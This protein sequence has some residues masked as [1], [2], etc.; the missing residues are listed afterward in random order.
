MTHQLNYRRP[1]KQPDEGF[2]WRDTMPS[3]WQQTIGLV[4]CALTGVLLPIWFLAVFGYWIGAAIVSY[5]GI[6]PSVLGFDQ[7]FV[8]W[9][10][11][12]LFITILAVVLGITLLIRW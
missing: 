3:A 4:V 5:R 1:E 9:G 2:Y 7:I 11:V 12:I 8:K 10:F 6:R